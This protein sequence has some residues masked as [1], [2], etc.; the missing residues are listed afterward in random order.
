[1]RRADQSEWRALAPDPAEVLLTATGPRRRL[2]ERRVGDPDTLHLRFGLA[3]LPARIELRAGRGGG[4]EPE[5]PP[6][7]VAHAVPVPLPLAELGVVG[8]SGA[9]DRSRALARWLVAQA[10][11]LHSPRDLS[12][13]VLSADADAAAALEL[14]ALAAALRAARGRGVRG[15]DRRRPGHRGPARHRAGDPDHRAPPRR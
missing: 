11:A 15:A 2:W 3:D 14:G 10:A 6:A 5:M 9:R 7:P 8:L 12:I 13:I 1:M 4:D